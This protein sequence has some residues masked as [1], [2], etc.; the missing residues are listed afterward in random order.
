LNYGREREIER[1]ERERERIEES[2]EKRG[3]EGFVK[4]VASGSVKEAKSN[5]Y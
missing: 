5:P 1:R 2:V 3:I 4:S